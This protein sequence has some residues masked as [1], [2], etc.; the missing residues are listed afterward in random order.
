KFTVFREG[1]SEDVTIKLGEQPDNFQLATQ[2]GRT[3]GRG[4]PET[5]SETL[6]MKL[7]TP[8]DDL[9]QKFGLNEKDGALVVNVQRNSPAWK[10]GRSVGLG[11]GRA[12]GIKTRRRG[13]LSARS[14][15]TAGGAGGFPA[16][17]RAGRARA[18]IAPGPSRGARRTR[19]LAPAG[20]CRAP[21]PS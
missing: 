7:A 16:R 2:N 4:Q 3:P 1:K 8:N 21:R 5:N 18:G 6:G 15:G 14:G 9:V 10:A 19:R 20:A 11:F 13:V 12:S 17:G